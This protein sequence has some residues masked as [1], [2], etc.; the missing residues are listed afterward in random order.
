MR[1]LGSGARAAKPTQAGD[2]EL[3]AAK[4]ER[5]REP[6]ERRARDVEPHLALEALARI[7][8]HVLGLHQRLERLARAHRRRRDDDEAMDLAAHDVELRRGREDRIELGA[9]GIDQ[10][11]ELAAFLTE[12]LR[13]RAGPSAAAIADRDVDLVPGVQGPVPY[14]HHQAFEPRPDVAAWLPGQVG[15]GGGAARLEPHRGVVR[16]RRVG[17]LRRSPV[18]GEAGGDLQPRKLV[19]SVGAD[20]VGNRPGPE[21]AGDDRV[22]RGD[23]RPPDISRIN[24]DRHQRVLTAVESGTARRSRPRGE[25]IL[26]ALDPWRGGRV[27]RRQPPAKRLQG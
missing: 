8:P 27:G 2:G 21:L 24:V 12:G 7:S 16:A 9:E 18:G 10:H 1:A 26:S 6:R 5:A 14:G 11:A 15:D 23:R 19:V 25:C 17:E 3:A 22:G 13:P 20:L 4:R